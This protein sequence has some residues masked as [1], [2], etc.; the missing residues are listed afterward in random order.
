MCKNN[1][2]EILVHAKNLVTLR[3]IA[4]ISLEDTWIQLSM[5]LHANSYILIPMFLKSSFP[6]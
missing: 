5:S 1:M 2:I 6:H 3:L 4:I